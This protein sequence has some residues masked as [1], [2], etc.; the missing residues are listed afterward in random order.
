M[1]TALGLKTAM[2]LGQSK[3]K[4]LLVKAGGLSGNNY[5]N[6]VIK[7]SYATGAVS[8]INVVGGLLG[9]NDSSTVENSYATGRVK[10]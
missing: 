1:K 6:S 7:N 5:S 4:V 10:H 8:G 2:Q 3:H 9:N